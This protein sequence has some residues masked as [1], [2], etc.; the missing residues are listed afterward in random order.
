MLIILRVAN[1]RAL[2]GAEIDSGTGGVGS[3]R[4]R[5]RGESTGDEFGTLSEGNHAG[6]AE[7]AEEI[8]KERRVD[9]EGVVGQ[10]TIP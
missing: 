7:V 8:R 4:F 5:S 3:I 9:A 2:I 1:R 6:S 10:V